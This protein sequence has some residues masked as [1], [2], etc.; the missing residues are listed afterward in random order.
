MFIQHEN[1][2]FNG[3][4]EC[5]KKAAFPGKAL[6]E[7]LQLLLIEPGNPAEDP[8]QETRFGRRHRVK[9]RGRFD[10]PLS[11]FQNQRFFLNQTSVATVEITVRA[12]AT[13]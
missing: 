13:A 1:A 2:I 7:R 11:T 8:V 9:Q 3:V 10:A 6:D 5:F 12:T 4:K